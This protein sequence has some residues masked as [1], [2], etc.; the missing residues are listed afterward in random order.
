MGLS[1]GWFDVLQHPADVKKTKPVHDDVLKYNAT[2]R[3]WEPHN[4][5]V[6]S[7]A[8][9]VYFGDTAT[10]GT[11]RIGRSGD[12]LSFQRREAGLWVSKGAMI[13]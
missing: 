10:N 4:V 11:W 2:T 3:R 7:A 12:K 13:P 9:F 6:L 8:D 1:G 5:S